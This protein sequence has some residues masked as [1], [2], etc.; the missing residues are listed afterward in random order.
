MATRSYSAWPRLDLHSNLGS[1]THNDLVDGD[2]NELDEKANEA[3]DHETSCCPDADLVK[4][5]PIWLGASFDK[6]DAVLGEL[7]QGRDHAV[8]PAAIAMPGATWTIDGSLSVPRRS[9]D[10]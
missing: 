6:P 3:H 2:E 7:F 1:A 9:Q 8:H 4:L 5:L 10:E